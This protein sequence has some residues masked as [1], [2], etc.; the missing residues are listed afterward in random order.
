[1][2][3]IN[4]VTFTLGGLVLEVPSTPFIEKNRENASDIMV[5]DGSIYTDFISNKKG[6]EINFGKLT[7]EQYNALRAVY[8]S[9]FTTLEYPTFDVPEMSINTPV[10]MYINDKDIKGYGDWVSNVTITLL[11]Q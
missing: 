3:S 4:T 9:Q 7:A 10:R 6:W 1:M 5:L 11:E 8:D 2:S